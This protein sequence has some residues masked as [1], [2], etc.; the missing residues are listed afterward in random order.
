ME[1]NKRDRYESVYSRKIKAGKRRTY[2]IDVKQTR[3][4]EYY[5]TMT[6][7]TQRGPEGNYERHKIFLY[8]ED[9]NSFL[10]GLEDVINHI[11]QNLMPDYEYK[12]KPL[13]QFEDDESENEEEQENDISW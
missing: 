10:S 8:R 12:D 7:S 3:N 6:E 9:F 1:K 11:K 4:Q 2:F 5:I 13:N